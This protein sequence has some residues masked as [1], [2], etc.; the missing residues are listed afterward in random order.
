MM[1]HITHNEKPL[2]VMTLNCI[3]IDDSKFIR[4]TV[5]HMIESAGDYKVIHTF[6]NGPDFLNQLTEMA[7][8]DVVF[9]D[10]ILPD[11]TGLDLL[12]IIREGFPTTKIVMLSGVTQTEAISAALRLGAID[13]LQKP[14]DK[15][16]LIE[17]LIKLASA[18]EP[19]SVKELSIIG[20]T[21]EILNGF[22][23]ELIAHSTSTLRQVISNQISTLLGEIRKEAEGILI[24]DLLK[25]RLEP[26]N[27]LWGVHTEEKVLKLL[28]RIPEEL[29]FELCFMYD[30]NYV[31]TLCEQAIMTMGAKK[32]FMKL[33]D[34]VKP[35]SI[36][37]PP[38][39]SYGDPSD[40]LGTK[41]ATTHEELSQA[42][43]VAY[44]AFDAMGPKVLSRINSELLTESDLMRNSIFYYTLMG[45]D[46]TIQ[47]GLFG[48]LPV[49]SE[50]HRNLSSLAYTTVKSTREGQEKVIIITIFYT[51]IAERIIGDYNRLSF[52]IRTRLANLEFVED[53]DKVVLRGIIDDTIEYLL[54]N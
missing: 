29:Q 53:I 15:E 39:P 10:I 14:V 1:T 30:E 38:V 45:D 50:T 16:R 18:A 25:I 23:D 2:Q 28:K 51:P 17:L 49:S 3:I 35:I 19:P 52:V 47:Q 9:C 32:R 37:L 40:E 36:G 24:I 5:S 7:T 48:P 8:P 11:M 31:A 12:N 4:D 34:Q 26:D 43:S 46:D 20:V 21:T 33:F 13:F 41:A 22:F 54:D 6:A 42:M 44:F 27:A